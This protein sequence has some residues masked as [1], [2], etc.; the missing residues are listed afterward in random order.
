MSDPTEASCPSCEHVNP[1]DATFCAECGAILPPRRSGRAALPS[2]PSLPPAQV[3]EP[4]SPRSGGSRGL[5]VAAAMAIVVLTG[6]L[7][8]VQRHRASG[9]IPVPGSTRTEA[10]ATPAPEARAPPSSTETAASPSAPPRRERADASERSPRTPAP[11]AEPTQPRS[12][13]AGAGWY[14]VRYRAPLFRDPSETSPVLAY[15]PAGSKVHVT[16][17]LPGFLAVESVMGKPPGYLSSDD[18]SPEGEP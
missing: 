4:L 11:R 18:A 16:R 9:R 8:A 13:Q 1:P 5:I 17:V 7:I 15:L 2:E 14:R 12:E 6:I 10:T 3:G